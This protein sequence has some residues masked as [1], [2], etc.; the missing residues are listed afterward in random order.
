MLIKARPDVKYSLIK[1]MMLR[2]N[3]MLKITWLCDIAG[4]SRSG[5]YRWC[6]SEESRKHKEDQDINDFES[7]L[8]AYNYRGYAKGAR[9]IYMRLGKA[10][11]K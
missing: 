7:I 3:N 10:F 5:Y 1:E 11:T 9:G 8:N 4:V 6:S 2:D